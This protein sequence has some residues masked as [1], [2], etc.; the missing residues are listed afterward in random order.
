MAFPVALRLAQIV[1]QNVEFHTGI[2]PPY[3]PGDVE[4]QVEV[5][6]RR[7]GTITD[8]RFTNRHGNF[9]RE[10]RVIPIA[11]VARNAISQLGMLSRATAFIAYLMRDLT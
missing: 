7:T 3:L 9:P 8:R 5:L 1:T 11:A 10:R 2:A 6:E 4:E